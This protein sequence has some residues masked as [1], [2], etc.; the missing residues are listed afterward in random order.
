MILFPNAKI[1]I[2]LYITEKRPDGYHN[3]ETI[4]YPIELTDILEIK[5]LDA[6]HGEY[7]LETSG[8]PIDC[9]EEENLVVKGYRLLSEEFDL[10]AVKIHLHKIIPQ[11][12]GLGGGSSDGA[13]ML[14]GLNE[15]FSLGL[16]E[17][18]L[19]SYALR[20]GS[21]APLFI[22]NRPSFASGRGEELSDIEL[23]LDGYEIR[24]SKPDG[25]EISTR[26]AYS[27]VTPSPAPFNLRDLATLDMKEWRDRVSNDFERSL[28]S[29]YPQIEE[30]K[31]KFYEE[32]AL[33]ASM[34]GSGSAVFGIFAKY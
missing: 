2:G 27:G 7:T 10:P 1:N 15:K 12:A 22:R 14:K 16:S 19:E 13:F 3:I 28:F 30:L 33:F 32:G 11:G 26:E 18:A 4:L 6:P 8:L 9:S 31:S 29:K 23:N 17:S 5:D 25:V 24:V 21:D 34:S 20:L